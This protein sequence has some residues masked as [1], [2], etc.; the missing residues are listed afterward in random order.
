MGVTAEEV[1]PFVVA[2][3]IGLLLGFERERH[4]RDGVHQTAGSR[5]MALLGLTGAIA[6]SIDTAVVVAGLVVVGLLVAL[7]YR[8]T[9][10][11]DPGTTT[12][13][14]AIAAYLLGAL[15]IERSGLA[16]GIAIAAVV[17][18][19]SKERLHAFARDVVTDAEV[20]DALKLLVMAFVVLPLL[21][22]RH[23]GPYG[24]LDPRR[25]W[26]LV[27]ALTAISWVGYVAT[28]A[29]GAKRGLALA[30][31]A[32]G[33]V[34]ASAATASMGRLS[35]TLH[36]RS[37]PAVGAQF[38]SL[39]TYVELL[40]IVGV[41]DREVLAHIWPAVAAGAVS[42]LAVIVAT[43]RR[44]RRTPDVPGD[45]QRESEATAAA[46]PERPF[47]LR[48]VLVLAAVLTGALLLARWAA[49]V[50]GASGATIAAGAAGL[51]DAHAASLAV[52]TLHAQGELPMATCVIAIAAALGTN[53]VTK[54]VLAYVAG[55]RSFGTRFLVGVVPSFA[56]T[57][58]WLATSAAAM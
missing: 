34:S 42:L 2:L 51:A 56:L 37:E 18:L 24:V 31:L 16:A 11:D 47:A 19:A 53:T 6:A 40:A 39:A 49:D 10:V 12:E 28:R 17:V 45:A 22:A 30:G 13:I 52:V 20:E 26:Q 54:C 35:R 43:D 1:L 44:G 25:I 4:H 36:G 27:I 48:P 23:L 8:R 9:S 32:G 21:P 55:G 29:L 33:F 14:A 50:F 58:A 7:G 3:A 46:V 5:T 41:A 57:I 38:A 15:A